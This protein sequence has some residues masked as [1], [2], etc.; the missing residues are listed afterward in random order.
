L[1]ASTPPGSICSLRRR[2]DCSPAE[3]ISRLATGEQWRP[4]VARLLIANRAQDRIHRIH[5]RG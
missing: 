2:A 1:H 4:T 3:R 5:S